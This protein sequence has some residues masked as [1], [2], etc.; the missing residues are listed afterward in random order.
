MLRRET[1]AG[2][3]DCKKALSEANGDRD[4]AL[5]ILRKKGQAAAEKRAERS[6]EEGVVAIVAAADGKSA[7]MVELRSETDFVARNEGFSNWPGPCHAD[8]GLVGW[9]RQDCRGI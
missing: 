4:K 7:A 1:G 3:M 5:E 8:A 9:R 2:M 6:A